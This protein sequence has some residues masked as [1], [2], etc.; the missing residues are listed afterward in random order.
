MKRAVLALAALPVA[1]LLMGGNVSA[2]E[3]LIK[4]LDDRNPEK[5]HE[6]L[7]A[8]ENADE[9]YRGGNTALLLV[10]KNVLFNTQLK[11]GD[12]KAIETIAPLIC[13]GADFERK[14]SQGESAMSIARNIMT[15]EKLDGIINFA[16]GTKYCHAKYAVLLDYDSGEALKGETEALERGRKLREK[17]LSPHIDKTERIFFEGIYEEGTNAGGGMDTFASIRSKHELAPAMFSLSRFQ[18]DKNREREKPRFVS[19]VQSHLPDFQRSAQKGDPEAINIYGV[20]LGYAG[21]EKE[22]VRQYK[23]AMDKG[24]E[25]GRLN[26]AVSLLFS[27]K[28]SPESRKEGFR[29]LKESAAHGFPRA[30]DLLSYCY[31]KG[32]ETEA[33]PSQA[34][35]WAREAATQGNKPA[36]EKLAKF[37]AEGYG[38]APNPERSKH[39]KERAK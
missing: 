14:N 39:W 30:Q 29:L 20:M 31:Y 12:R 34:F 15:R 2:S 5:I 26:Y 4:A 11:T 33:N 38:T 35:Y 17:Y 3:Q 37:Y 7:L 13:A 16:K 25:F 1:A 18:S 8:G 22:A 23:L 21:Q 28:S 19:L 24:S 6:L 9:V 32:I 10:F 36:M 27:K